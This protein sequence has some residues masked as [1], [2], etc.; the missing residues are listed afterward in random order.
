MNSDSFLVLHTLTLIYSWK[1][2]VRDAREKGEIGHPLNNW[3]V[4][5]CCVCVEIAVMLCLIY[6]MLLTL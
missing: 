2:I 5:V 3:Y 1:S 6:V 4:Y